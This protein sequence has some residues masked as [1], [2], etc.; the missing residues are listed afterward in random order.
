MWSMRNKVYFSIIASVGTSCALWAF[1]IEPNWVET[2]HHVVRARVARPLTIAHLSDL[3]LRSLGRRERTVLDVVTR[4]RPDAIVITGDTVDD[5]DGAVAQE[6]MSRLS[7]PLGVF[8]VLGNWEHWRPAT[9][10]PF[11]RSRV[12]LLQNEARQLRDNVWVVGFD[13]STAGEPNAQAGVRDVP[14]GAYVIAAMHSPAFIEEVRGDVDLALAG[15]THGGQVRLPWI[16]PLWLPRGSADFV[17]G[18]YRRDRARMYV[19]RGV[20]TSILPVRFLCRP[21]VALINLMP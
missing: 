13:D 11:Q 19:S 2:T 14:K 21:E 17:A 20:G 5:G 4:A 3:H 1:F 15:H 8:A 18:W 16:G 7:A 6:F 9:A 12:H 10:A